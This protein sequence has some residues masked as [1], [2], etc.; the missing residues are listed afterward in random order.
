MT[1]LTEKQPMHRKDAPAVAIAEVVRTMEADA[2][3]VFGT[4]ADGGNYGAVIPDISRIEFVSAE[5]IGLGA[6]FRETR[7]LT[8]LT[9]LLA[10]VFGV[11]ATESEC[12]EFVDNQRVRYTTDDTGAYWHSVFTVTSME[13]RST[14]LEVRVETQPH[15]LLGKLVPPLLRRLVR[16]RIAADLDAVKAYHEGEDARASSVA[17][18]EAVAQ[19]AETR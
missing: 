1:A 19:K 4:I 17:G 15:R 11:E 10:R 12:T 2:R 13:G 16:K 3:A 7:S 8:G 5:R 14:R 6:R 18:Y 9:A